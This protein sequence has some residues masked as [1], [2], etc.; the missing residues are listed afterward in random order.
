[1]KIVTSRDQNTSVLSHQGCSALSHSLWILGR[2]SGKMVYMTYFDPVSQLL[3][4]FNAMFWLYGNRV[5][6]YKSEPFDKLLCEC[7][8]GMI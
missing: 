6:N 5:I 2:G 1:M 8:T 7:A 3:F 4:H